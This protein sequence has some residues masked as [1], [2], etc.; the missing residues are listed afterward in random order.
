[1]CDRIHGFFVHTK[2]L[3]GRDNL[4]MRC[5]HSYPRVTRRCPHSNLVLGSF[6]SSCSTGVSG[7]YLEYFAVGRGV[8]KGKVSVCGK[9]TSTCVHDNSWRK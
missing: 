5:L 6:C 9:S 1:M 4:L 3:V 8:G 7:R 2:Q